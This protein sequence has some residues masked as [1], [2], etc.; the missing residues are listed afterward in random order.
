MLTTVGFEN[1]GYIEW[2]NRLLLSSVTSHMPPQSCVCI[3]CPLFPSRLCAALPL[4]EALVEQDGKRVWW[5]EVIMKQVSCLWQQAHIPIDYWPAS[6]SDDTWVSLQGLR[7]SSHFRSVV[8]ECFACCQS[9]K[10]KRG[11]GNKVGVNE[12][13]HREISGAGYW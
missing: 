13:M 9:S 2:K 8:I 1:F 11:V 10:T 6:S 7:V 3:K 4:R 5:R 12:S